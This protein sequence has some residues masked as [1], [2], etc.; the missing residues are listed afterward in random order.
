MS[1]ATLLDIERDN[2]LKSTELVTAPG[3]EPDRFVRAMH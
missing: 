1:D 3:K 2:C